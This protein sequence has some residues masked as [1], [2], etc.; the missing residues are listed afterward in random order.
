MFDPDR[1]PISKRRAMRWRGR[2]KIF[3]PTPFFKFHLVISIRPAKNIS[4]W[5]EAWIGQAFS[6]AISRRNYGGGG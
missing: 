3:F 2:K 6:P 1:S 5:P 4:L